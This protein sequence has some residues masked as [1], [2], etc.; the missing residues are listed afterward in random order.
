MP[1]LPD[2]R[3][4]NLETTRFTILLQ[5]PECWDYRHGVYHLYPAIYIILKKQKT[6]KQQKMLI[7]YFCVCLCM[8]SL[9]ASHVC[10]YLQWSEEGDAGNRSYRCCEP[11]SVAI[12]FRSPEVL[13]STKPPHTTL[14]TTVKSPKVLLFR[15]TLL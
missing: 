13:L 5:P 9:N 14:T 8:L 3:L 15:M 11:T 10:R 1:L 2:K 6:K 12:K 7:Y 4:F